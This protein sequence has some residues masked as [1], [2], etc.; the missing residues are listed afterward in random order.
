MSKPSFRFV[1]LLLSLSAAACKPVAGAP[2]ALIE[3]DAAPDPPD[4]SPIGEITVATY[5]RC[6]TNPDQ[7]VGGIDIIAIDPDGTVNTAVTDGAGAARLTIHTGATVT[8]LYRDVMG[9]QLF[10]FAGVQPGDVLT[11]GEKFA[12]GSTNL[13][14]MTANFPA[15]AQTYRVYSKCG[16]D[17][18]TSPATSTTITVYD[19]CDGPQDIE[20]L[21]FDAMG[22]LTRFGGQSGVNV[23]PGG[24]TT[25]GAWQ[26][27][28]SFTMTFN[29]VPDTLN[30]AAQIQGVLNETPGFFIYVPMGTPVG[31]T[32]SFTRPWAPIGDRII[33]GARF[34][35]AGVGSQFFSEGMPVNTTQWVIND[36]I[37]LPWMTGVTYDAATRT[38]SVTLEGA[39][40]YD[41]TLILL[42]YDRVTPMGEY[43]W[44][45]FAPPG[46]AGPNAIVLPDLPTALDAF[47]PIASDSISVGAALWDYSQAV[48]FA[49]AR[50]LP[51]WTLQDLQG[52]ILNVGGRVSVEAF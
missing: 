34:D 26:N 29:G 47:Q 46:Q 27:A 15:T 1:V 49:G 6:C 9:G 13:G 25:L 5:T 21:G 31:G 17:S 48:D 16:S 19:D 35:N 33:G 38:A 4:A 36:P 51:E 12:A 8:A 2:D 37:T 45:I 40:A 20:Y 32:Y 28:T 39:G 10:T 43:R 44:A 30:V 52:N 22:N 18:A 24:S 50:A 41:G 42:Q 11:F 3:F 7:V 23:A 14:S